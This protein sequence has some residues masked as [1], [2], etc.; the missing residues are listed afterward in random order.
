MKR[1]PTGPCASVQCVCSTGYAGD[2][3]ACTP[4]VI[5]DHGEPMPRPV[6]TSSAVTARLLTL[7]RSFS[8]GHGAW[9]IQ[10]RRR[11]PSWPRSWANFSLL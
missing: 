1:S 3:Y 11:T 10:V 4:I 5:R 8:V 9:A 2:G 7:E 6:S